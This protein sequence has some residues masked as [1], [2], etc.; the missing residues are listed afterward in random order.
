MTPSPK[1]IGAEFVSH[2][3]HFGSSVPACSAATYA[4]YQ[5]DQFGS[6]FPLCFSRSSWAAAA[7]PIALA[8]SFADPKVVAAGSMRP[9]A[10]RVTSWTIHALPSGSWKATYEL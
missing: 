2:K 8:R 7:R 9:G 1:E 6:V 10:R 5:S 4:A 3:V